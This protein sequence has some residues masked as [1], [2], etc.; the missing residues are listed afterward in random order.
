MADSPE[1]AFKKQKQQS[2][3]SKVKLNDLP[4]LPF[5]LILSYL[6]LEDR[7]KCRG[8]SRRWRKMI[9]DFKVSTLCFS[10]RPIGFIPGKNQLVSGA[11]AQ[12]FI[13]SPRFSS[14]FNTFSRSILSSLKHLRLR[15]FDPKKE[16]ET[17]FDQALNAF[18]QLEELHLICLNYPY[19]PL[20]E[21]ELNLPMLQSFELEN[22]QGIVKLTLDAPKLQRIKCLNCSWYLRPTFVH[23]ESVEKLL[24]DRLEM[25][26]VNK[27]KNLK[28]LYSTGYTTNQR[29]PLMLSNLKHL[30]EA[31]LSDSSVTRTL[32]NQKKQYDRTDLKI[33][34]R[35]LL[36]NSLDDPANQPV[37]D[38]S[39][40]RGYLACLSENISRVADE[41]PFYRSTTYTEIEL[42]ASGEEIKLLKRFTDLETVTVHQPVQDTERFLDLLANLNKVVK[43]VFYNDQP[44]ELFDRLP[45]HCAVQQLDVGNPMDLQ[46]VRRLN[47]LTRLRVDRALDAESVR[48]VLESDLQ[49]LNEFCFKFG[50]KK[51]IIYVHH[52]KHFE[53]LVAKKKKQFSDVNAALQF[54]VRNK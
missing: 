40:I 49:F 9:D 23:P 12:N 18:D 39:N 53:V 48:R 16:K 44:Q 2:K 5:E 20:R 27:L 8:V 1:P 42:V 25:I 7:I 19:N 3:E 15:C 32:F 4:E 17:I 41:I 30:K 10:E 37:S 35:G 50:K 45:E 51:F 46:F 29:H 33:F 22:V 36:L 6:S 43:L 21:F 13:Q 26:E 14:F 31:H 38:F 28:Y 24:L 54:V 52:S 11:Y 34:Q 47:D